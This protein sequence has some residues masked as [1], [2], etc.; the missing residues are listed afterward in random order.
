MAKLPPPTATEK[1]VPEHSFSD[2]LA[3]VPPHTRVKLT[4]AA[5]SSAGGELTLTYPS[6]QLYCDSDECGG[7]RKHDT[8]DEGVSLGY[9]GKKNVTL[10]FARFSCRHCLRANKTFALKITRAESTVTCFATKIGESPP[11]GPPTPAKVQRLFGEDRTL[12]L[13]GR[14]AE[15][16]GMGIGAFAYYRRVVENHK[17][18]LIDEIIRVSK[19]LEA[20]AA[21]IATLEKAK[22]EISFE[23]S[24]E[25][26]KGGVPPALLLRG[27]HNPLSLLHG[28]LSAGL[29][30]DDDAECLMLAGDIR[31]VLVDFA[32]RT[33]AAMN[34][35]TELSAAVSRLLAKGTKKSTKLDEEKP[36]DAA[37]T[38]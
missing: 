6:T 33:Q 25:M 38:A 24:V 2:F 27:G 23:K 14:N 20:P 5:E 12:Y 19:H 34:E 16:Q 3:K 17:N 26:I 9:F 4:D 30:N 21:M 22:G 15:S 37:P 36:G 1:Q 29:H 10:E 11:F 31:A 8:A 18:A 35:S 7:E 28:A 13:K 32:E